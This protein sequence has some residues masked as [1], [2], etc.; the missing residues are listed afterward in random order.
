[1]GISSSSEAREVLVTS[2][3]IDGGDWLVPARNGII[4]SKPPL[5][6]WLSAGFAKLL[7]FSVEDVGARIFLH[8]AISVSS[9]VVLLLLVALFPYWLISTSRGSRNLSA[10]R[11]GKEKE[12]A[13]R[14]SFLAVCLLALTPDFIR[15]TA[16]ARVDMLFALFINIGVLT[17]LAVLLR[18]P[19]EK[20]LSRRWFLLSSL[21]FGLAC[22]TKGPLGIGLSVLLISVMIAVKFGIASSLRIIFRPRIG[23]LLLILT[24]PLW[25]VLAAAVAGEPF[26]K[27][28]LFENVVRLAGGE[29]VTADSWWFYLWTWCT[30]ASPW[31]LI[32][33]LLSIRHGVFSATS[34]KQ[35]ASAER[36]LFAGIVSGTV[37]LSISSG[38]RDAYLVPLYPLF[39]LFL[40]FRCAA[41]YEGSSKS[42]WLSFHSLAHR[43]RPWCFVFLL[44]V[45]TTVGALAHGWYIRN[46]ITASIIRYSANVELPVLCGLG[47]V[48]I[49]LGFA[50]KR[51]RSTSPRI[52]WPLLASGCIGTVVL[53][54][55]FGQGLKAEFKGYHHFAE[56]IRHLVP[57]SKS[58]V[59]EKEWGDERY[60]VLLTYLQ[61]PVTIIPPQ[62]HPTPLE[63]EGYD[64]LLT[65]EPHPSAEI[66]AKHETLGSRYRGEDT[67]LALVYPNR[68]LKREGI[69]DFRGGGERS[70]VQ[71][72][73]CRE[74]F[75]SGQ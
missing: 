14:R 68:R 49:L 52:R 1:M 17:F 15:L 56:K 53:C 25:Y 26:L 7:P 2:T 59:I 50:W 5:H 21:S 63:E 51:D 66:L 8:R 39:S 30:G 61:R 4:A 23:W 31:S 55:A 54:H 64:Y 29:G 36:I 43:A 45:V 20:V 3:L 71:T 62:A 19:S 37:L 18:S 11:G 32:A 34:P 46:F 74:C 58:I 35:L 12:M 40:A 22:L 13:A 48:A 57:L 9:A 60:D 65:F 44:L 69:E 42:W 28:H 73:Q 75:L 41:L 16:D 6:H 47:A 70:R 10:E 72:H 24:G 27:R 33:V 67:S 38:K